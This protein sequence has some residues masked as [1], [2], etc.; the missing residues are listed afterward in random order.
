MVANTDTPWA[1]WYL[2][3]ATDKR[4]ARLNVITH[5]LDQI[6]YEDLTPPPLELP[7]RQP[8]EGYEPPDIDSFNVVPR[9]YP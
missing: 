2:V 1:P 5:L 7:P 6:P 4:S 8:R 3:D 9:V